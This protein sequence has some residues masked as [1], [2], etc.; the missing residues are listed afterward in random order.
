MLLLVATTA[1]TPPQAPS[2]LRHRA[3]VSMSG[4]DLGQSFR[5][6][7]VWSSDTATLADVI[8]CADTY[9]LVPPYQRHRAAC[10]R[11]VKHSMHTYQPQAC[12]TYRV[13][14]H[15]RT[16]Y[17]GTRQVINVVGRWESSS[18]WRERTQFREDV[19]E[20]KLLFF[21]DPVQPYTRK[22]YDMSVRL[23]SASRVALL[24]NINALP[25]TNERLAA[26]VGK[27]AAEFNAAPVSEAAVNVVFDALAESKNGLVA[28]A[29]IDE[30]RAA[31]LGPDGGFDVGAYS[32][33]LAKAQALVVAS[34]LILYV[35]TP[36]VAA[37]LIGKV[38]HLV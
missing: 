27:S 8:H 11:G 26:S 31:W 4:A 37:A 21:E 18:E 3:R 14:W 29:V 35:V 2:V 15:H 20:G 7:E 30:R 32:G 36:L 1:F 5:R 19:D 12:R 28:Y 6:A 10:F 17:R 34:S 23:G 24:Q 9:T 38:L 33:S 22:K 25:F 16:A 13:P